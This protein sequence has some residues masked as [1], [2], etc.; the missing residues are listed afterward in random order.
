MFSIFQ[1]AAAA[2]EAVVSVAEQEQAPQNE[3][4]RGKPANYCVIA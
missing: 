1:T 2:V 4:T 3:W